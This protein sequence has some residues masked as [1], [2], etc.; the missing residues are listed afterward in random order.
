METLTGKYKILH[1]NIIV[2]STTVLASF[3][4]ATT[5]TRTFMT[6][7]SINKWNLLN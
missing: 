3:A 1:K 5:K 6:G 2:T 4:V 7:K